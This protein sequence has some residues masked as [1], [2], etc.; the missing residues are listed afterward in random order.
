MNH[1]GLPVF[2]VYLCISLTACVHD[3]FDQTVCVRMC[4][5]VCLYELLSSFLCFSWCFG[6]LLLLTID[7][8]DINFQVLKQKYVSILYPILM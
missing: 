3:I 5:R 6:T 2:P 7:L 8:I 4:V 1:M